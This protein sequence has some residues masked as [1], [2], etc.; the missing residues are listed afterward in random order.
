MAPLARFCTSSQI[1]FEESYLFLELEIHYCGFMLTAVVDHDDN[2]L[3][4]GQPVLISYQYS[5]ATNP[6]SRSNVPQLR[7]QKY[8]ASASPT[9]PSTLP[10]PW[11]SLS[12][13]LQHLIAKP[14]PTASST[15]RSSPQ[16][17]RPAG[18]R[19]GISTSGSHSTPAAAA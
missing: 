19:C 2:L 5:P 11:P 6:T 17:S 1:H 18:P 14:R 3:S 7:I 4:A 15:P 10:L 16:L 9:R 13:C 12:Q 8:I